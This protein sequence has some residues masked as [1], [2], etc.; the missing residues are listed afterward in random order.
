MNTQPTIV[1]VHGAWGSPEMWDHV[2]EALPAGVEVLVADLPTCSR[3]GATLSDDAAHVRELTGNRP[4]ILVGH[5]YGGAVI[6]EAG[7]QI[8]GARHMVFVAAAMPDIGESMFDWTSKRPGL[9]IPMEFA[10]DGTCTLNIDGL[11]SPYDELTMARLG[12]VRMRPFAIAAVMAPL[13]NAAW[14]TVPST[15]LVATEDTL[16]HPDTQRE[17]AVRAGNSLELAAEHQVILSHPEQ[18]AKVI[19]G[20]L[21][22]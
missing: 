22:H 6:S 12:R 11:D 5:S 16:I 13:T 3:P 20:V 10:N 15:Y 4:A 8:P 19:A 1:L 21:E 9:E 14:S 2:I 17:M 7:T 18:V